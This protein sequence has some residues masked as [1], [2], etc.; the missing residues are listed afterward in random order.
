A[1]GVAHRRDGPRRAARRR[2]LVAH[3]P[4]A[5]PGR[6]AGRMTPPGKPRLLRRLTGPSARWLILALLLA[7]A[8]AGGWLGPWWPLTRWSRPSKFVGQAILSPNGTSLLV[9]ERETSGFGP[10]YDSFRL[11]DLASGRE[12]IAVHDPDCIGLDQTFAPDG[13]WL[14]GQ[15]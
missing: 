1:T 2:G 13:S 14:A 9:I 12:L 11:W 6:K 5:V 10:G 8:W 15:D 3:P 4:A 7:A